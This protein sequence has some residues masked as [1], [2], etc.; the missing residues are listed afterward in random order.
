MAPS[1]AP[2]TVSVTRVRSIQS[3]FTQPEP[4]TSAVATKAHMALIGGD[5]TPVRDR[6]PEGLAPTMKIGRSPAIMPPAVRLPWGLREC[7]QLSL[8]LL[9]PEAHVHLAVHRCRG[10][11]V[12]VA[13]LTLACA[14]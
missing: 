12:L 14:P 7:L 1:Q 11:E 3:C 5:S 9:E 10:G 2:A 6:P 8:R 13:L 4:N